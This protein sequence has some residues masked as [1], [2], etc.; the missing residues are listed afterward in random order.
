LCSRRPVF[1][2]LQIALHQ[3]PCN[4]APEW[5]GPVRQPPRRQHV[6]MLMYCVDNSWR[7]LREDLSLRSL[8]TCTNEDDAHTTIGE[9]EG[10]SCV[11]NMRPHE[12][13]N[14]GSILSEGI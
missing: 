10:L 1:A 13:S 8:P 9:A 5:L 7:P 4:S 12:S 11:N 14:F 2:L 3:I 6:G